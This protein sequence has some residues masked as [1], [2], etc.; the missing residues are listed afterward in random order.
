[1][2]FHSPTIRRQGCYSAKTNCQDTLI[3]ILVLPEP[4]ADFTV[5]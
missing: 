2:D 1:M 4:A 3:L 5:A